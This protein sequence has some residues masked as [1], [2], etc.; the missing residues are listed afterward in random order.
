MKYLP[1]IK[2]EKSRIDIAADICFDSILSRPEK[3]ISSAQSSNSIEQLYIPYRFHITGFKSSMLWLPQQQY[4]LPNI[5]PYNPVA[6]FLEQAYSGKVRKNWIFDEFE[7]LF[8]RRQ[9]SK[10]QIHLPMRW[11]TEK[12]LWLLINCHK[13]KTVWQRTQYDN[14]MVHGKIWC[15]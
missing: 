9:Q 7:E 11:M 8:K 6:W 15:Q 13:N 12:C 1:K 14:K 10:A 2:M 4:K 5:V 3:N